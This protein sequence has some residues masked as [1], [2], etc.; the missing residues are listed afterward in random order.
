M[1]RQFLTVMCF[2]IGTIHQYEL[3]I[4]EDNRKYEQLSEELFEFLALRG[5][6]SANTEWMVHDRG[7]VFFHNGRKTDFV[8]G[9]EK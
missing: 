7:G 4:L 2:E 3:P 1:Q 5:F 8:K 9:F 6:K